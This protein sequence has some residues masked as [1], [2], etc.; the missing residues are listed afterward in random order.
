VLI[1]LDG[2]G[3]TFEAK[4]VGSDVPLVVGLGIFGGEH[5]SN[6]IFNYNCNYNL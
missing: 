2:E 3:G 6:R 1:F 5:G 4:E